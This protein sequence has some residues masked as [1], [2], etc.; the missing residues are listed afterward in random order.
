MTSL[1]EGAKKLVAR[2]SDIGARVQ[3]LGDAAAAARG[4]LDDA[5]LDRADASPTA[6]RRVCGCRPTT[7]SSRSAGP[8]A[9]AS[10]RRSTP[11]SGS[12][13]P[14]SAYVVRRRRGRRPARGVSSGAG[15]LL[16]WLGIPPRHQVVRDSMLDEPAVT[17]KRPRGSG[18][19]R[20]ARPRLDGGRPP[21]R[22]RPAGQARRP[23]GLGARSAEVRRRSDPRP[24]PAP[25]GGTQ[26]T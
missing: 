9:R 3:A 12:T 11:W 8:P 7:R 15:E 1:L 20:P 23:A 17:A 22:G 24:V 18:P 16:E 14:R 25:A 4:R 19:A 2:G 6:L 21:P 26:A 5:L 10:P 13:W